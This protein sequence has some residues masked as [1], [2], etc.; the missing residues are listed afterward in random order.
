MSR[1][2]A[3]IL[4]L[5]LVVL[6]V[7]VLFTLI[8]SKQG[9]E[10]QGE[11]RGGLSSL[12]P[13]LGGGGRTPDEG[14]GTGGGTT[15]GPTDNQNTQS[16]PLK[17]LSNKNIAG[18]QI[19]TDEI[20]S[21]YFIE[22]GTGYFY[23]TDFSGHDEK[24]ITETPVVRTAEA[25]LPSSGNTAVIRYIKNDNLGVATFVGRVLRSPTGEEGSATLEG[26]FLA[27]NIVDVAL[28]PDTNSIF[29]LQPINNGVVGVTENLGNSERKQLFQTPFTEWLVQ[30]TEAGQFITTKAASGI[31]GYSYKSENGGVLRKTIGGID[32]LTTN[33]SPDGRLI[34]Y[35]TGRNGDLQ[36][37]VNNQLN[38]TNSNLGIKTL[39]EKCVWNNESTEVYCA[40]PE[41]LP[42][43]E[44]PDSWYQ[45]LINFRDTFWKINTQT[46]TTE[47]IYGGGST[48]IDATHPI[49]DEE[50]KTLFFLNK[51]DGSLWSLDLNPEIDQ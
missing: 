25:Y 24:K 39:S 49:L 44:Y 15:T 38:K 47:Q 26:T 14:A 11:D 31:P 27:D 40:V 37:F 35:S 17:Q 45:G 46:G 51:R 43:G 32:G 12:F 10:T 33:T 30:W 22:K 3:F 23:E 13:F 42:K 16:G 18:F 28:S 9:D 2:K 41:S 50:H 4:I 1:K 48:L 36:L 29:Y 21:I 34:L 7:I 5:T 20:P 6:A 19:S 8:N